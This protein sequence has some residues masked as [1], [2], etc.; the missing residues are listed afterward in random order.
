MKI[1]DKNLKSELLYFKE[2]VLK[3]IRFEIS[4]FV[5]KLDNQKS[6]F[7]KTIEDLENKFSALSDKFIILSNTISE[8]K[9]IK[10][11]VNKLIQFQQ[12]AKETLSIHDSKC[13]HN[14]KML[15]EAMEKIDYFI[16]S[17]ILYRDVIG[18]T[19]KCK[20]QNFHCF[21]DYVI[22][23]ITQ[24]NH[25]KDKAASFDIK[26]LWSKIDSSLEAITAQIMNTSRANNNYAKQLVEKEEEK[27]IESFKIYDEKIEALKMENS[28]YVVDIKIHFENMQKEWENLLSIRKEIYEKL[29]NER[30]GVIKMNKY[31]EDKLED[32][33]KKTL[34]QNEILNKFIEEIN[35]KIKNIKIQIKQMDENFE[36]KLNTIIN[37]KKGETENEVEEESE[38]YSEKES[39]REIEEESKEESQIDSKEGSKEQI[40][41]EKKEESDKTNQIKKTEKKDD[42]NTDKKIEAKSIIKQYIEGKVNYNKD[43]GHKLRK[44]IKISEE[45]IYISPNINNINNNNY[46]NNQVDYSDNLDDFFNNQKMKTLY[47]SNNK[48]LK[49]FFDRIIIRTIINTQDKKLENNNQPTLNIL[50]N[51]IENRKNLL[52]IIKGDKT[53]NGLESKFK[54]N[55]NLYLDE[56]AKFTNNINS[57]INK[58]YIYNTIFDLRKDNNDS[59]NKK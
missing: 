2:E 56:S 4:K 5:A 40:K 44:N 13:N 42:I 25:F 22:A 16:N 23:N 10:E 27:R 58:D 11:K 51:Q 7:S 31:L 54:Y 50:K 45:N 35:N 52:Q 55:E 43:S 48:N 39:K 20:F 1:E 9:S 26:S 36:Y 6:S 24:L 59:N 37:N 19:P 12:V 29:G 8:D 14:S 3:D 18:P 34:T 41:E 38:N 49:S 57:P 47:N 15:F 28:K 30:E 46:K 17:S 33:Q 53:P 21:I 32:Y